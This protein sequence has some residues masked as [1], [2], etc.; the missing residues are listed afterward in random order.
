M[1][2]DPRISISY[3]S[4]P[5]PS[6]APASGPGE[7]GDE[8]VGMVLGDAYRIVRVVGEGGTGRVY[9]ARHTRIGA[10]RFAVKVLHREF[11]RH[12]E[13]WVRFQREA[14]AAAAID[15]ENVVDVVDVDRTEDGRPYVVFEFLEGVELADYIARRGPLPP[16]LAANIV[17][18]VCAGLSV[19]HARGVI[20]RDIKPQ[21]IWLTGDLKDP[22]VKVL[23]FGLSRPSDDRAATVTRTGAVLG[24]PAYMPP[25][26]ARGERVDTRADVYGAG[27]VLYMAL[28]G[29]APFEG[30]TVQQILIKV[31]G[32]D[33]RRPRTLVSIIP[34]DLETVIQRAMAKEPRERYPTIDELF[35]A[36]EPFV[37]R[38]APM[39]LSMPPPSRARG[40]SPRLAVAIYV[41]LTAAVLLVGATT[42]AVGAARALGTT[43][44]DRELLLVALAV[45]GTGL[46]PGL[47]ALRHIKQQIWPNGHRIRQLRRRLRAAL[48]GAG[49][50]YGASA[51]TVRLLD[52]VVAPYVAAD[53]LGGDV[54]WVPFNA[55]HVVV[56]ALGAAWALAERADDTTVRGA[57]LRIAA[58]LAVLPALIAGAMLWRSTEV[59][60][61]TLLSQTTSV[62]DLAE[63]AAEQAR[64]TARVSDEALQVAIAGGAKPLGELRASHPGDRR[65]LAALAL[66]LGAEEAGYPDAVAVLDDLFERHPATATDRSLQALLT[67]AAR[68]PASRDAALA[69]ALSRMGAP[70]LD[71]LYRWMSDDHRLEPRVEA[72]LASPEVRPRMPKPLAVAFDLFTADGCG[73]RRTFLERA[74]REGDERAIA[75]LE[76]LAT[77]TDDG[78]GPYK[79][80]PCDPSC[81]D[82]AD[83]FRATNAAIRARLGLPSPGDGD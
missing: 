55:L 13:A 32:E 61:I 41:A 38:P 53:T 18:Q 21:N 26:Q 62:G 17:Q 75:V 51:A 33:P 2:A 28:T 45:A 64:S 79:R 39:P 10:K 20:H 30:E 47:L 66:A 72:M 44:T 57:R 65:V 83:A 43:L 29:K 37:N 22:L 48:V 3:D 59:E 52:T 27:A 5:P 58:A 73:P 74:A 7:T 69:V 35:E 15:H 42:F 50:G 4:D 54:G 11:V 49:A 6:A 76:P 81:E 1:S 12:P 46:S 8:L 14:E 77:G 9:Q 82:E 67:R 40:G 78:C 23:D 36:L 56:A 63:A 70:G 80:R 19:A 60:T 71:L 31:M 24:T 16:H 34:E 68:V 25:E